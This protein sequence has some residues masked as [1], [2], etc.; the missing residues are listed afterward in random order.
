M[1]KE[2]FIKLELKFVIEVFFLF[3]VGNGLVEIVV[4]LLIFFND[5]QWYWV[6]VERNVKQV[7][8]QVDW[9]FQQICKVLI[10]GYICLEFYSQLFVGGVGGQQGFLGCICFLRMN[11]VI[12]DLEERVKVIFG[13]IFGC[14]GY[15]ISYGINCEN[16]GKCLERYYGY[17][18]DCFNI[19]YDGIFCNKD[20]GVFFEEGMWL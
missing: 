5:D 14:L 12:F 17:F 19:V 4:R 9:L 11:G 7:S 2:D 16:G 20:V 3:D 15:C 13:F 18:C 6:I 8:L 1:G 10:E